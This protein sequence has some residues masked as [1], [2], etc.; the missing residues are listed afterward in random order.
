V[1]ES[2]ASVG[3]WGVEGKAKRTAFPAPKASWNDGLMEAVLGPRSAWIDTFIDWGAEDSLSARRQNR[4]RS[5][6]MD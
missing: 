4:R 6:G 3:G 2:V 1:T 5:R